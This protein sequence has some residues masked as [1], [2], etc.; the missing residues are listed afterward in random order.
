[1]DNFVSNVLSVKHP[2]IDETSTLKDIEKEIV[3]FITECDSVATRSTA[4]GKICLIIT[5][6]ARVWV[7]LLQSRGNC[8]ESIGDV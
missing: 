3:R 2:F 1:M 8:W 7:D 5:A 4:C 6:Y